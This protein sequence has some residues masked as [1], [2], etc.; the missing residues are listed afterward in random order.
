MGV[1]SVIAVVNATKARR[2]I[3]ASQE[4]IKGRGKVWW[5]YIVGGL[6][7]LWWGY[8]LIMVV[9]NIVRS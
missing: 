8:V 2:I 3:E 6:G 7:L 5:C 4:T 9:K 1:G